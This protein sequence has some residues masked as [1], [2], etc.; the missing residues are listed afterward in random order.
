MA[1][2][3]LKDSITVTPITV[4]DGW[5]TETQATSVT[6]KCR[7]DEG[8]KLVRDQQGA[9]VVSNTQIL[10]DKKVAVSY[11]DDITWKDAVTGETRTEKPIEISAI[12]DFSSKVLFTKVSL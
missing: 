5:G 12:K 11:N 3:P 1:L 9:E 4:S 2:I 8:T 10:L 7:I 6:Y